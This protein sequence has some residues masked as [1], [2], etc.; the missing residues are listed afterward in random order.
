MYIKRNTKLCILR[1]GKEETRREEKEKG[2]EGRPQIEVEEGQKGEEKEKQIQQLVELYGN[3]G[4]I[5]F[6]YRAGRN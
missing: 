1:S 5:F 4:R 2:E 6:R 3:H